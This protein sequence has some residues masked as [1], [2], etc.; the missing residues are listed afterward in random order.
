VLSEA[1]TNQMSDDETTVLHLS[2]FYGLPSEDEL[3]KD[4][5]DDSN[6]S[7]DF[8]VALIED[9]LQSRLI[10]CRLDFKSILDSRLEHMMLQRT[11]S[12]D[13]E[14]LLRQIFYD[15]EKLYCDLGLYMSKLTETV[16]RNLSEWRESPDRFE[17]DAVSDIKSIEDVDRQTLLDALL[18]KREYF[19]GL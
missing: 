5:D 7:E 8:L 6:N 16:K 11:I 12:L 4:S 15:R 2:K 10:E 1:A 17:M 18:M 9:Y 14:R 13:Q 19:R 3:S